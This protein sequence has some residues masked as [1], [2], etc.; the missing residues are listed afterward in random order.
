IAPAD[1][2]SQRLVDTGVH[3]QQVPSRRT[4]S[5]DQGLI[6]A[7]VQQPMSNE[8]PAEVFERLPGSLTG[9][10]LPE[11]LMVDHQGNLV[12]NQLIRNLFDFYLTAIGEESLELIIERIKH[13]LAA[14]LTGSALAQ[15]VAILTGYLQYR[16]NLA[17]ILNDQPAALAD[18]PSMDSLSLGSLSMDNLRQL[19]QQIADSRYQ[20][21]DVQVIEAFFAE[22]DQYDEYMLAQN[23]IARDSQLTPKLRA[24]A[25]DELTQQAPD[26]LRKQQQA[27]NQLSHFHQQQQLLLAHQ[28]SAADIQRLREHTFGIEA[29][30]RLV[31]LAEKRQLWHT[32]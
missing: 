25:L 27:A 8:T 30:D 14:Q 17:H 5:V 15:S 6:S 22:Q 18:I 3:Q 1:E 26:W 29:A 10:P 7:T 11:A 19:K 21:L 32:R 13:Q 24:L 12:V 23:G 28:G 2:L 4:R 9:L 20:F 31:R 16:N